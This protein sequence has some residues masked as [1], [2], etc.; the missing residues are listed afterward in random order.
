M[1]YSL[2]LSLP[3]LHIPSHFVSICF[4]NSLVFLNFFP[5]FLA[6]Y[7]FTFDFCFIRSSRIHMKMQHRKCP[8]KNRY[9]IR[10]QYL[11]VWNVVTKVFPSARFFFRKQHRNYV[12]ILPILFFRRFHFISVFIFFF[13]LSQRKA[14]VARLFRSHVLPTHLQSDSR[15]RPHKVEK[16]NNNNDRAKAFSVIRFFPNRMNKYQWKSIYVSLSAWS[17]ATPFHLRFNLLVSLF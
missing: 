5:L 8:S 10:I 14:L 6:S 15:S 12:G 17:K 2:F 4:M 16:S 9:R 1:A 7:L 3:S 13:L 11:C